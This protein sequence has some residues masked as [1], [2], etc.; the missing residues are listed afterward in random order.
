MVSIQD[1]VEL[2]GVN[3]GVN[4]RKGTEAQTF[5]SRSEHGSISTFET[6]PPTRRFVDR[7]SRI[8]LV[9]APSP[10]SMATR[11]LPSEMRCT[12]DSTCSTVR[13]NCCDC[14]KQ[15]LNAGW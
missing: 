11:S 15:W 5:T 14:A 6:T 3:G 9:I 10:D 7:L 2:D 1:K 13:S 8:R 12:S 4:T